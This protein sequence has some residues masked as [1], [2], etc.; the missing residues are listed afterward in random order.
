MT[1]VVL[2]VADSLR[3]DFASVELFGQ[4]FNEETWARVV[5]PNTYTAHCMP[6]LLLGD[7]NHGCSD[8]MRKITA[9][10][11]LLHENDTVM[12]SDV[13]GGDKNVMQFGEE[14]EFDIRGFSDSTEYEFL[15]WLD[16]TDELPELTIYH[17]MITHWPFGV[18]DGGDSDVTFEDG[19]FVD[20]K[21]K[22]K[23]DR[24]NYR[25]GVEA[26]RQRLQHIEKVTDDDTVVVLTADHG[27]GLGERGSTGHIVDEDAEADWVHN[28]DQIT[29]D[30]SWE[31]NGNSIWKNEVPL[32]IGKDVDIREE[33]QL[34][35]VRSIIASL[36][37][38]GDLPIPHIYDVE[39]E[40][41][42]MGKQNRDVEEQLRNLGYKQ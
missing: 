12:W 2:V 42:F 28:Q 1:K 15:Q 13:F 7:D 26:I 19:I 11:S 24:D 40:V 37:A 30:K 31:S 36:L 38:D 6:T 3:W 17:S 21:S 34:N 29:E 18:G 22:Y 27:E 20:D 32:V 41:E 5:T 39:T 33:Y 14:G 10:S 4:I 35:Q 9:N 25:L 23:W 8:F 16:Q